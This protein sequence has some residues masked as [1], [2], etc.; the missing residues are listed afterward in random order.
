MIGLTIAK[1]LKESGNLLALVS[2]DN[3]FPY[4]ANENTQLPLIIY[5]VDS[6]NPEYTK[7]GWC[8]DL[9]NFSVISFSEDYAGLQAI[10]TEVRKALEMQYDTDTQ[11]IYVT[12]MTEGFNIS[13]NIF[14]NKLTFKIEVN[15]Y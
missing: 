8:G 9:I 4:V 10:S 11:R 5:T 2:T 15:K 13:E 1:L 14:L 6:I 3:I 7:D 12:G